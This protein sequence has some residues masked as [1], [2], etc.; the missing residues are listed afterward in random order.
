MNERLGVISARLDARRSTGDP[1]ALWP[2]VSPASREEAHRRIA[3]VTRAVLNRAPAPPRLEA[4]PEVP[5]AAWTAAAYL[6][7]MGPLIGYWIEREEL[8]A[9]LSCA[10]LFAEHLDQGRRRADKLAVRLTGLLDVLAEKEITPT[11]L[12]GSDTA[13]RYFPEPGTRPRADIDLLV[14]AHQFAAARATL[15]AA[16]YIE[17]RRTCYADRSEWRHAETTQALRSLEVDHADNPWSV[18]LH[19]ALERWYFRG[20]RAGFGSPT[21]DHL[22]QWM[23]DGRPVRVLAQPLLTAFLALHA[24]YG[25]RDFRPLRAVELVLVVRRDAGSGALRWDALGELLDRTGTARFVYPALELAERWVPGALD[26]DLRQQLQRAAT[27][28]MRR[29]VDQVEAHGLRLAYRSLDDKL[30]WAQSPLE[31]LGN[32][33]ELV[34]SADD[35]MTAGDQLRLHLRR[36]RMLLARRTRFRA[37]GAARRPDAGPLDPRRPRC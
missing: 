1:D 20:L 22:A 13:Y 37:T 11:L 30:M 6:S 34:W 23:F 15:E 10:A 7:G 35:T 19:V 5:A 8:A 17:Y 2:R 31:W 12:K 32:L 33:S 3:A 25:M 21:E 28:R 16:G 27:P 4:D 26:P 24:S 9:D 36:A 18:D 29:V 14:P